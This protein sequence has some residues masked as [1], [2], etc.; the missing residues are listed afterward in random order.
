MDGSRR[1][2]QQAVSSGAESPAHQPHPHS[3]PSVTL[4]FHTAGSRLAARPTVSNCF[5][6]DPFSD[7][8]GIPQDFTS[9]HQVTPH[10]LFRLNNVSDKQHGARKRQRESTM[11]FSL[12]QS[13]QSSMP[14]RGSSFSVVLVTVGSTEGGSRSNVLCGKRENRCNSM[15]DYRPSNDAF[16]L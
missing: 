2:D 6:K 3:W 15:P 4:T 11:P 14:G 9:P 8:F 10:R 7:V 13:R 12:R 1:S 5:G 16:Q